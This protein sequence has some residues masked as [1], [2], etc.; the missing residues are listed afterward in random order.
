M[1]AGLKMMVTDRRTFDGNSIKNK[2]KSSAWVAMDPSGSVAMSMIP[3][4]M[5]MLGCELEI[6]NGEIDPNFTLHQPDPITVDNYVW[7]KKLI[8]DTER[9]S[10]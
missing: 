7:L 4:L 8:A 10:E 5:K 6:V 3:K 2:I 9:I 1:V